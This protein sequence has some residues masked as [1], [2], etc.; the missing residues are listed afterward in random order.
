MIWRWVP[1]FSTRSEQKNHPVLVIAPARSKLWITLNWPAV[2]RAT[3]S[4]D[5]FPGYVE[6][7]IARSEL[8]V[9]WEACECSHRYELPPAWALASRHSCT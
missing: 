1:S 9:R 7:L 8:A 6:K 2:C 3:S 5:A 4:L